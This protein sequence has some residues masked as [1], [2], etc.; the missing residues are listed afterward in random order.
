MFFFNIRQIIGKLNELELKTGRE[1]DVTATITIIQY[2]LKCQRTI[3][4]AHG[5]LVSHLPSET[6][7]G[8][9][10]DWGGRGV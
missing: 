10:N 2:I 5:I 6:W 4:Y 3:V 7:S 8:I 9:L 1:N